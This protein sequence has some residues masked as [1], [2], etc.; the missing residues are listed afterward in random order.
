MRAVANDGRISEFLELYQRCVAVKNL[1]EK[2]AKWFPRWFEAYVRHHRF[3]TKESVERVPVTKELLILFLQ[4][5]RDKHVAAWQRLQAMEA[6]EL[7]Y[8]LVLRTND[9]DFTPIRNKLSELA[10]AERRAGSSLDAE[11][12]VAGEGNPGLINEDEPKAIVD[13]RKRLRLLHHPISTERA[14]LGWLRRFMRH[15]GDEDPSRYGVEQV[16]EFLSELA[17]LGQVAAST[18]NQALNALLFYFRMVVS[19]DLGTIDAVRARVSKYRPTVLTRSEVLELSKHLCGTPRL[20][21]WLMY[22]AGLRHKECRTLRIKDVCLEELQIVVRE[23]KGAADR[24][25]VLPQHL[26]EDLRHHIKQ[27]KELHSHDLLRGLGSVYLP[28]A[29]A[30]KYPNADREFA[31]QYLF[32]S[33]KLSRDPRSGAQRRHHVHEHTFASHLRRALRSTEIAKPA[34]PHTLRHSFAT[35]MLED[36]ADIRTVQELLG[37]KDVKTTMIYTHVMNRPGIGVVSPCD[38]LLQR[39]GAAS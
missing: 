31:W 21:F 12:H 18:Q 39:V 4:N 34:T 14:Y 16:T 22:G 28:Y 30:R 38:R 8:H 9:L 25:T 10:A 13:M 11:T 17:L 2:A 6:I 26:R 24:V 32:P 3:H 7:Y 23:C 15:V 33:V 35:H 37:H 36:G 1:N 27:V 20:M 19:K 5:L 29:L